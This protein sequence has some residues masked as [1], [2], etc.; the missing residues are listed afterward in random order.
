MRCREPTYLEAVVKSNRRQV[1]HVIERQVELFQPQQPTDAVQMANSARGKPQDSEVCE[2]A[3]QVAKGRKDAAP[4]KA[5]LDQAR[6]QDP[7]VIHLYRETF[8]EVRGV[9]VMFYR[10][11]REDEPA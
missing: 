3:A 10:K 6:H 8:F 11:I 9:T 7:Q 5:E 2:R 1:L 4:L